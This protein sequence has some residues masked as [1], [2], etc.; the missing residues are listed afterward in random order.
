[1]NLYDQILS[2]GRQSS[3]SSSALVEQ[4]IIRLLELSSEQFYEPN[5]KINIFTLL[6]HLFL[7]PK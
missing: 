1:M 4:N 6:S 3:F 7:D 5:P 2:R